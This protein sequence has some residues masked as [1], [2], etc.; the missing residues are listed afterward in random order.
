MVARIETKHEKVVY[1]SILSIIKKPPTDYVGKREVAILEF[2]LE[3]IALNQLAV[4][5]KHVIE[6]YHY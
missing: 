4:G 2:S 5:Q 1:D 6:F 3:G